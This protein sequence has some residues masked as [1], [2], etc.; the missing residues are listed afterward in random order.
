MART[1]KP[2]IQCGAPKGPGIGR[3]LCEDCVQSCEH[4]SAYVRECAPCQT[5]WRRSKGVGYG[6]SADRAKY[7]RMRKYG[8]TSDEHDKIMSPGKCEVCGSVDRLCIDHD[9]A[10]EK[11]RGLLCNECNLALGHVN[12]NISILEGLI[13]YLKERNDQR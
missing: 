8:I 11:T 9:H 3:K 12:D 4:H 6:Y 10:T 7:M 13:R 5:A 1:R 2:C